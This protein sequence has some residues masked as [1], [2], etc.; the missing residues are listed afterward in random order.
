MNISV[1]PNGFNELNTV[2]L[3]SAPG[4]SSFYV[5]LPED[6]IKLGEQ[7]RLSSLARF[8]GSKTLWR[9]TRNGMGM[10]DLMEYDLRY[11]IS[12]NDFA[13]TIIPNLYSSDIRSI[14]SAEGVLEIGDWLVPSCVSSFEEIKEEWF[15]STVINDKTVIVLPADRYIWKLEFYEEVGLETNHSLDL[16]SPWISHSALLAYGFDSKIIS[17]PAV[18][19]TLG[20][21]PLD[22]YN[23]ESYYLENDSRK[24][25][26]SRTSYITN[27]REWGKL[28]EEISEMKAIV[29][30]ISQNSSTP[31]INLA[32]KSWN[33][34]LN[35]NR[36]MNKSFLRNDKF[37]SLRDTLKLVEEKNTGSGVWIDSRNGILLG[38]KEISLGETGILSSKLNKVRT[39]IINREIYSPFRSYSI[40]EQVN[41]SGERW[42]SLVDQNLGNVPSISP[43]WILSSEVES[44]FTS[45]IL[46][47]IEN[48]I[49][50]N[51]VPG[52]Y[53]TILD[54]EETKTFEVIENLGYKLNP[55][56]PAYTEDGKY[57]TNFK[58]TEEAENNRLVKRISIWDWNSA[59]KSGHLTF[60]FS[61]VGSSICLVLGY[62]EVN[63]SENQ[64]E[65][66]FNEDVLRIPGNIYLVTQEGRRENFIS[67]E[68][69]YIVEDIPINSSVDLYFPELEK[70]QPSR[71]IMIN[72]SGEEGYT[73]EIYPEILPD[74]GYRFSGVT[75][76]SSGLWTIRLIDKL[77]TINAYGS[78][79]E[80]SNPR[81]SVPYGSTNYSLGFYNIDESLDFSKWI[82]KINGREISIDTTLEIS[83]CTIEY[84]FNAFERVY[85]LRWTGEIKTNFDVI[86]SKR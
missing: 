51:I 70:Y 69:E 54:P 34:S 11:D 28:V 19:I 59:I 47:D 56:T 4:L 86:I 2:V 22:P 3:Y 58:I 42:E 26:T 44:I 36:W 10:A 73:S 74:G 49:G 76:F 12:K 33:T 13:S 81:G 52:G 37:Y 39:R 14:F 30:A 24:D 8:T 72:S 32:I 71:M 55:L 31:E 46:F 45:R 1:N 17:N 78:D 67:K 65:S 18:T 38:T 20:P 66:I 27:L 84:S 7:E 5:P 40:G 62:L 85:Y 83:G 80:F 75:D 25:K 9:G 50:G 16:S 6:C 48:K 15:G 60:K 35:P 79:F 53:V 61:E 41:F 43:E 21:D 68:G 63:Y 64:W 77:F 82:V 57:I 29:V 23:L